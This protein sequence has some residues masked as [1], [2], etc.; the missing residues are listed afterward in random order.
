V[1]QSDKPYNGTQAVVRALSVL[2][3]FTDEKPLWTL[4]DL[5]RS[6][7]LNKT[8]VFRLLTALESEGL[9]R[10]ISSGDT[11]GLGPEMVMLGARAMRSYPLREVCKPDLKTLADTSRET[12]TLEI[13]TGKDV[14]ILDEARGVRLIGSVQS[15]GTR[16]PAFATSTGK[17]I[18]AYL[19]PEQQSLILKGTLQQ[20]TPKTITDPERLRK[21]FAEI[22]RRGYA[23]ADE[24]LELGFR[25]VGSPLFQHDGTVVA[26]ISVGG[27]SARM[28]L[29]RLPE[30]GRMVSRMAVQI[31]MRLGYD[32]TGF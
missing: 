17:S 21:E 24:A 27:P 32:R 5:S 28:T 19:S 16:W 26:A 9:V 12:A 31:S 18:L 11:Y 3:S 1:K 30:F 4:A 22:K 13:L 6:L 15:I 8:T 2:K 10:R 23:V 14:L 25:A 29:E 7:N 20:Y